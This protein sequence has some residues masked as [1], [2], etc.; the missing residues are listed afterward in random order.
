MRERHKAR[1]S[2]TRAWRTTLSTGSKFRGHRDFGGRVQGAGKFEPFVG[3]LSRAYRGEGLGTAVAVMRRMGAREL[4]EDKGDKQR[5][6]YSNQHWFEDFVQLADIL[7]SRGLSLL[8]GAGGGEIFDRGVVAGG[9][10]SA[11]GSASGSVA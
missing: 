10:N 2:R 5:D 1:D 11:N 8:F 4:A 9:S 3:V 7:P 6:P